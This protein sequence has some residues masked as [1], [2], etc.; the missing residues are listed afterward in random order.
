M[1]HSKKH[2]GRENLR[3]QEEP[4]PGLRRVDVARLAARHRSRKGE[5]VTR[6]K[7]KEIEVSVPARIV[8]AR[9]WLL[10]RRE[11]LQKS[12]GDVWSRISSANALQKGRSG[13]SERGPSSARGPAGD[14]VGSH[15]ERNVRRESASPLE[16][17]EDRRKAQGGERSSSSGSHIAKSGGGVAGPGL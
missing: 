7:R 12:V 5:G 3:K 6:K 15:V 13:S 16:T 1:G 14:T 9:V 2:R 4:A 10:A 17:G 11:Q 8:R